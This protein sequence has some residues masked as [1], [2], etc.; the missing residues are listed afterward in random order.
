MR[1]IG[2]MVVG[3]AACA[4]VLGCAGGRRSSSRNVPATEL[5]PITA[6]EARAIETYGLGAPVAV[7]RRA[8]EPQVVQT[9]VERGWGQIGQSIEGRPIMATTV[10]GVGPRVLVIGSIHGNELEGLRAVDGLVAAL[11]AD[12][13][14][15]MVRLVRDMN[16]DGSEA[17]TRG[18]SRGV[19]LNRNWPARNFASGAD[20][21]R[22]ALS[23][24]ECKALFDEIARFR[25]GLVVVLHSSASGPFV[26]YDGPAADTAAA[27]ASAAR[28]VDPRWRVVREMGYPTPGS[29]G[30]LIG[31][32]RGI[33]ILTIEF[34]RGQGQDSVGP[35]LV[36][37]VRAV[38]G[39]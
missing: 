7:D 6:A 38:C 29:L 17:R 19:D 9:R 32:D 35:A 8:V 16:P 25:P 10:E 23:E 33:P 5:P 34:R 3:M 4:L 22:S 12:G 2:V 14:S 15:A 11:R 20:R 39:G 28:R 27:F 30:S 1:G 37:G 21:G 36:A 18:N 24:P 13:V 26:N 31:D